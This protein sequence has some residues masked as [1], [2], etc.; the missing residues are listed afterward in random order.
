VQADVWMRYG[1][2]LASR[3]GP[4]YRDSVF[5]YIEKEDTPRSLMF[6]LDLLRE[7]GFAKVEVLHKNAVFAAF[8]AIKE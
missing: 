8:G 5:A 6:Q 1:Q 3:K 7:A 2:Y 4:Q